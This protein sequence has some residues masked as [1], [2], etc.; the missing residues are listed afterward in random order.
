MKVYILSENEPIYK[1]TKVKFRLILA[2]TDT[3]KIRAYYNC[4][5]VFGLVL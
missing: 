3:E 1:W 5:F 2:A 4:C